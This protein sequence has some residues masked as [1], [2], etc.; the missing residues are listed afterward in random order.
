MNIDP[1]VQFVAQIIDIVV[2]IYFACRKQKH[3]FFI[4][5]SSRFGCFLIQI[6]N[7]IRR[8]KRK[9]RRLTHKYPFINSPTTCVMQV[10]LVVV[11]AGST[12]WQ[13]LIILNS[14]NAK[15]I[16]GNSC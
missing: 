12:I 15:T 1:V 16:R 6:L 5:I 13:T 4:N 10:V 3:F 2:P 7:K 11:M 9:S 8:S 14:E